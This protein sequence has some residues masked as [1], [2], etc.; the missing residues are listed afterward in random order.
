MAWRNK[1]RK[2]NLLDN[3]INNPDLNWSNQNGEWVAIDSLGRTQEELLQDYADRVGMF[4]SVAGVYQTA[5][6]IIT[7]DDITVNVIDDQEMKVPAKTNGKD[8]VLNAN[9]IEDLD[10]DTITSLHGINYHELAHILFTPRS[11]SEI[12]KWAK[13]NNF[14]RAMNW[15]EES[16]AESLMVAKYPST[17][18]FLEATTTEYLLKGSPSEWAGYFPLTT[19]RTYLSLELRQVIANKFIAENGLGLATELSKIIHAYRKLAFPT[20]SAIGKELIE[21]LAKIIGT[22]DQLP[23]WNTPDTAHGTGSM[24]K[25]RTES[26]KAQKGLLDKSDKLDSVFGNEELSENKSND[27]GSQHKQSANTES[28]GLGGEDTTLSEGKSKDYSAEDKA[29]ADLLEKRMSEIKSNKTVKREVSETHKAINKSDYFVSKTRATAYSEI[30]PE[31]KAK[32]I[33][34]KF[35]QELERLVLDNEPSWDKGVPSGKLNVA[36]TMTNDVNAIGSMFDQWDLGNENNDIEA[37]ILMDNSGSMGWQ[38][39]LVCEANWII[40]RGVERINGAVSTF[41][42]NHESKMMYDRDTKA[43]ANVMRSVWA[44]GNTNPIGALMEAERLLNTS[45]K[46]IKILFMITDGWWDNQAQCDTIIKR[47]NNNGVLTALVY[48]GDYE[49]IK[50]MEKEVANNGELADYYRNR[51]AGLNHGVKVFKVITNVSDIVSLA[52]KLVKGTLKRKVMN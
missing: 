20:D 13:Q 8:I 36:R 5:D 22:D 41:S 28:G 14:M 47:L 24:S 45:T 38:M 46:P 32:I 31:P 16:R 33:A 43:K 12:V 19:G 2:G 9:L 44:G 52:T 27:E 4:D 6:K 18:L 50:N 49:D 3:A 51:L 37:V 10:S 7:G 40:K 29:I 23:K 17:R 21:A 39:R 26:A 1:G 35:G 25:G 48:I 34:R 15:L 30:S 42:F 11:G